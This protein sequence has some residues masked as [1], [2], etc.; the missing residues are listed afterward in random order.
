MFFAR[1]GLDQSARLAKTGLQFRD[2]NIP[3]S[4]KPARDNLRRRRSHTLAD[5][6]DLRRSPDGGMSLMR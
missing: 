4:R 3:H 1:Q 6:A 5:R 2:I